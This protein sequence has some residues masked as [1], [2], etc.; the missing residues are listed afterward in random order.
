MHRESRRGN[1]Q[2]PDVVVEREEDGREEVLDGFGQ[3]V[4]VGDE[5]E[6]VDVERRR[7]GGQLPPLRCLPKVAHAEVHLAQHHLPHTPARASLSE[8]PAAAPA[9]HCIC[10]LSQGFT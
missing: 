7:H 3:G 6:D 1:L 5:G 8:S 9:A 4:G 2:H 10:D